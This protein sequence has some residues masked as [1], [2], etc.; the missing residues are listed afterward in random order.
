MLVNPAILYSLIWILVLGLYNLGLSDVL[1]PLATNTI[2]LIVGTSIAFI[3]GFI[4]E[5]APFRWRLASS[6]INMAPLVKTICSRRI[7]SRVQN[8]W[9]I[10]FISLLFEII[11]G[12]GA[13]IL[14]IIGIGAEI[15]YTD[16]GIP[17]F[18][19]LVNSVF[20]AASIL[21]F[22]RWLLRSSP[23]MFWL[24]LAT[25]M[26]PLLGM[27][28][29]VMISLCV[30]Y[31]FIYICVRRPSMSVALRVGV[32]F[33]AVILAFGYLGDLRSGREVIIGWLAPNLNYPDWL[34]SAFLW[35]YLYVTTPINNVNLNIAIEPNY[36]PLEM[37]GTLVP[38][39]VRDAFMSAFGNPRQWDLVT[40]TFNISSLLQSLLTDLGV[41]G[42]I[43]FTLLC[44]ISFSHI[45]RRAHRSPAA[46]LTTIVL[47]HGI[48][49]SFFAN[50][51]FHLV[52]LFEI[53][54]LTW[55][56]SNKRII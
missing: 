24:I 44:G 29:Q 27:S 1:E 30:Q 18:H 47:L 14:G 3:L 28:R 38:S 4:L 42:S 22:T 41:V 17:G 10:F 54:L 31:F 13:P 53:V 34:P 45:L 43:F 2:V 55:V 9:V 35:I 26:Y 5:S 39:F 37:A 32:L 7:G 12:G 46:L 25:T 16:F 51:L 50:L 33:L 23:N 48:A 21:T 20:Y 56:V 40:E 52:F 6:K 49:L 36:F 15:R 11:I 8:L 19:G